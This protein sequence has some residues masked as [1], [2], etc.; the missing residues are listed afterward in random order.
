MALSAWVGNKRFEIGEA[1]FLK[2]WFST[3]FVR[4]EDESWGSLF[5]TIMREFYG[6]LL[7]SNRAGEALKELR[8]IRQHL[9]AH[10]PDRVVWDFENR[11]VRPPWGDEISAHIVSLENYFVTSDGKDLF[12][13][14]TEVFAEAARTK[15]DVVIA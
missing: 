7:P 2:A 3:V 15:R 13:V 14:L 12:E 10:P 1:S 6:G 8:T 4:L 11:A 5:P 9:G